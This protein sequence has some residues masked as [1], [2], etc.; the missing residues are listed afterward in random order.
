MLS[1]GDA[2][3][4][5]EVESDFVDAA[6]VATSGEVPIPSVLEVGVTY[7]IAVLIVGVRDESLVRSVTL[8]A[9][10]VAEAGTV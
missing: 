3:Q 6:S 4:Y 2:D 7:V 8:V 1:S 10:S 5:S 9:T